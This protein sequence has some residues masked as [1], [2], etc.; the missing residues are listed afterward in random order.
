MGKWVK[1]KDMH[2]HM[3]IY[4]REWRAKGGDIKGVWY[5]RGDLNRLAPDEYETLEWHFPD[6]DRP[7]QGVDR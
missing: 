6:V 4:G 2:P 1:N 5:S 3:N 7:A